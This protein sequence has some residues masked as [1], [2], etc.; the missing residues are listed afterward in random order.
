MFCA[1]NG[2]SMELGFNVLFN[3]TASVGAVCNFASEKG[4]I[5]RFLKCLQI[6][7]S[8]DT[9]TVFIANREINRCRERR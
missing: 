1:L 8:D 9:F 7:K 6:R 2:F 4:G 3:Y 5:Q